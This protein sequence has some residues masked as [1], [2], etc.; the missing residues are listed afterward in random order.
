MRHLPYFFVLSI[1]ISSCGLP[2]IAGKPAKRDSFVQL[3][4]GT[5]L[6]AETPGKKADLFYDN[7]LINDTAINTTDVAL[8]NNGQ[9]T[10]GNLGGKKFGA[11][12]ESGKIS[13]F[14]SAVSYTSAPHIRDIKHNEPE[15]YRYYHPK[16]VHYV[17]KEGTLDIRVLNYKNLKQMIP[18]E[19][20]SYIYLQRYNHTRMITHV[21]IAGWA[22]LL[23]SA[24]SSAPQNSTDR[25]GNK[26]PA[27]YSYVFPVLS[28]AIV[29]YSTE[30]IV[31]AFNRR[32]LV[33]GINTFNAD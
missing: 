7:V 1:I 28:G 8:F 4:N 14:N 10:Y 24:A 15:I 19:S 27:A 32:R 16:E 26:I 2:H 6:K 12:I 23:F 17:Q 31:R 21:A 20:S 30:R 11:E 13:V 25:H 33:R 29:F 5:V 3:K 9:F 22:A 18:V